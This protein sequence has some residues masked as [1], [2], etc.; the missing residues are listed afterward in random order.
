[1]HSQVTMRSRIISLYYKSHG[2]RKHKCQ[3]TKVRYMIRR[4]RCIIII[5]IWSKKSV[6]HRSSLK[7]I[8]LYCLFSLGK[9]ASGVRWP[10][11][12]CVECRASRGWVAC[13]TN[14]KTHHINYIAVHERPRSFLE[15]RSVLCVNPVVH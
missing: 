7:S 2:A 8:L 4:S 15:L 9:F 5:M 11:S 14:L 3:K 10:H 13:A 1:M 12:K 6:L